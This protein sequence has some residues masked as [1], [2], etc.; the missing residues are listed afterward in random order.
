LFTKVKPIRVMRDLAITRHDRE[1]RILTAEYEKFYF[2][3][4]YI[5]NGGDNLK[6][7]EYRI[8]D[9]DWD[10]LCFLKTLEKKKPV[11]VGGDLNVAHLDIDVHKPTYMGPRMKIPGVTKHERAN[12]TSLL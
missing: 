6:R 7:I 3:A 2:V 4:A 12:F 10:F 1:G 8:N 11:L 5:P 9:W